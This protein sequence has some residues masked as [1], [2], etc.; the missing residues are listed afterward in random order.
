MAELI[1]HTK[2]AVRFDHLVKALEERPLTCSEYVLPNDEA[3]N[4]RLDLQ[5]NLFLLTLD[6][7]LGLALPNEPGAKVKRVLDVGTGTG[8]WAIDYADEHPEAQ[9]VGVDLSPIQPNFVPPNLTFIIDDIEDDWTYNQPFDYIHSRLM[10]SSIANWTDYLSKCFNNLTPGGYI[11]LQEVDLVIKCDD[12]TL[13]PDNV[14]LKSLALLTEASI[15]LGRAYQDI[16]ALADI[17]AEIG[18]VDIVVE[19]FKWPIN[20]WPKDKKAKLLGSWCLAN[21]S[22]GLEAFTMAPLTRAHGWTPE[23]VRLFLVDQRKAM[24]DRSTHAYW[25][26]YSI[27]ARKPQE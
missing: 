1:T 18:F 12:D 16:P 19:K 25:P 21:F 22:I 17:M 4:E 24:S 10:T 7:K 2:T 11:E 6:D 23:E 14:M 27:F 3:E 26:I 5:H 9:V 13:S 8:I 20:P 15:K